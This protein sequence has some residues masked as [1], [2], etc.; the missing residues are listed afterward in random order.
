MKQCVALGELWL[1]YRED[2]KHNEAWNDFFEWADIGLPLAYMISQ[3]LA[4]PKEEAE[5]FIEETWEAFCEM[6]SIDPEGDYDNLAECFEASP[7]PP[8]DR[9]EE[10]EEDE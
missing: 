6:I 10:I 5:T 2:A 1:F 8:L 4:D 9:E 3:D 7:N